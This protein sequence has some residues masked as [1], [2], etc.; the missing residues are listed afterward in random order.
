MTASGATSQIAGNDKKNTDG[1]R[2]TN[3]PHKCT[4]CGHIF[5]DGSADILTGCPECGWNKFLYVP[6]KSETEEITET[7]LEEPEMEEKEELEVE[8]IRI[9]EKGSYE[10]NL[11]SLLDREE[12][13]MSV[14]E[15]GRYLVHLPSVFEKSKKGQ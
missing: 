10:L 9:L 2:T 14:K 7:E 1:D 11:K 15:D 6:A 3:M 13:I 5:E 4:K 12:I 8:S